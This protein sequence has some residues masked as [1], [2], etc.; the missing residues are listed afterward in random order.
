MRWFLPNEEMVLGDPTELSAG[1]TFRL[2][3]PSGENGREISSWEIA[4]LVMSK[5]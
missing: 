2:P 3:P 5:F 4:K 1:D